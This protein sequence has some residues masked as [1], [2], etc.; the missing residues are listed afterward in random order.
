MERAE[1]MDCDFCD[2]L[3]RPNAAGRREE[4]TR[5]WGLL[6]PDGLDDPDAGYSCRGMRPPQGRTTGSLVTGLAWPGRGGRRRGLPF[7]SS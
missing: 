4:I 5:I 2:R 1:Y 3:F 7:W 6:D